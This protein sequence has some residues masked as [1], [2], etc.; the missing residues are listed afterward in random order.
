M[1][2]KVE[3]E[4]RIVELEESLQKCKDRNLVLLTEKNDRKDMDKEFERLEQE[5]EEAQGALDEY[6]CPDCAERDSIFDLA[7][8]LV[9]IFD[10]VP[11]GKLEEFGRKNTVDITGVLDGLRIILKGR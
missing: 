1:P 5:L 6:E 10:G 8:D 3:L 9:K 7:D 4:A 11:Y 2:L